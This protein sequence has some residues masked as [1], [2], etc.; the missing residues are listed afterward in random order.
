MLDANLTLFAYFGN[1]LHKFTDPSCDQRPH[2]L[3]VLPDYRQSLHLRGICLRDMQAI[4]KPATD[5]TIHWLRIFTI[6]K[7]VGR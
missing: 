7:R 6:F 3:A 2:L 5:L 1:T 4:K